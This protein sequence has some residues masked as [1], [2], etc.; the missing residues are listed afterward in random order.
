MKKIYHIL[1]VILLFISIIVVHADSSI[2][3]AIYAIDNDGYINQNQNGEFSGFYYDYLEEIKK[4]TNANYEL[5]LI[6]DTNT[7]AQYKSGIL[8]CD[9][10]LGVDKD[11]KSGA[12]SVVSKRNVVGFKKTS[13]NIQTND[14]TSLK[15]KIVATYRDDE[16]KAHDNFATYL[17]T[18]NIAYNNDDKLYPL[19]KALLQIRVSLYNKAENSLDLLNANSIDAILTSDS[20]ALT[21]NLSSACTYSYIPKYYTIPSNGNSKYI[22]MFDT[23]HEKILRADSNFAEKIYNK[24]FNEVFKTNVAFSI[25][26][27]NYLK[28]NRVFSVGVLKDFAPYSYVKNGEIK[29]ITIEVFNKISELTNGGFTFDFK[30]YN[31]KN[32][33]NE[34]LL[35]DECQISGLVFYESNETEVIDSIRTYSFYEDSYNLYRKKDY[36]LSGDYRLAIHKDFD[37]NLIND[38]GIDFSEIIEYDTYEECL[39]SIENDL[40]DCA[41]VMENIANYYMNYNY[42]EYNKISLENYL[43]LCFAINDEIDFKVLNILDKCLKA[44]NTKDI[45][46][47]ILR[48]LVEDYKEIDNNYTFNDFILNNASIVIPIITGVALTILGLAIFIIINQYLHNKKKFELMFI[49]EETNHSNYKKFIIDANKVIMD[50]PKN[51][52]I[53]GY[54]DI[55]DYKYINDAFGKQTANDVLKFI[56]D[57]IGSKNMNHPY[58]R[59]HSDRFV[60]LSKIE[61]YDK[62]KVFN[63]DFL[64]DFALKAKQQFTFF[65][66][67]IKLGIYF[68]D[69]ER[70]ILKAVNYAN[71]A[72]D[73][74]I[75]NSKNSSIIYDSSIFEKINIRQDIERDMIKS[76]ESDDFLVYYQPKVDIDTLEIIGAEALVRWKHYSKG[77]LSPSIFI[78]IFETN[79]FIIEIDFYVFNQVCQLLENRFINNEKMLPISCNFSRLH[80]SNPTFFTRLEQITSNYHFS[81][82]YIEIEL[83]ETVAT[84]NFNVYV[85]AMNRLKQMG[86]KISIDDF[87]SG[88]S[89]IQLLYSFPFDVLKLDKSYIQKTN[90]SKLEKELMSSIIDIAHKNN[91]IIICE[92]VETIAHEDL[93]RASLCRYAQGFKYYKPMPKEDFLKILN[94][95]K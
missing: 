46:N 59:I 27:E 63:Q 64:K 33:L 4:K 58:A 45:D 51:T 68:I 44:I 83:T 56:S 60:F 54:I 29:G 82:D 80:L 65:N 94:L 67:F 88:Y 75:E 20:S 43:F 91:I 62:I 93:M 3:I 89:S 18:L 40:T 71:F 11:T 26:E 39:L 32:E 78:P 5:I 14:P 16:A 74:I 84:E 12:Y 36:A 30:M 92:G 6:N 55:R 25:N 9:L 28:N 50:N 66:L 37:Q 76:L 10:I 52:Y 35:K 47:Y 42:M 49:D 15:G 1:L 23:A 8:S 17:K 7:L 72:V 38:I 79:G 90:I 24:Y 70:D 86:F 48:I 19:S 77:L 57:Y 73:E 81:L 2:K 13:E 95:K 61:F 21:N 53:V 85:N 41:I 22:E 34:A 31:T 87:G 69:D